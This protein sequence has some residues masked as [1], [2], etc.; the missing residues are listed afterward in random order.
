LVLHRVA[1][2]IDGPT[3]GIGNAHSEVAGVAHPRNGVQMAAVGQRAG[4]AE[5][6][7]SGAA[8]TDGDGAGV[9]QVDPEGHLCVAADGHYLAGGHARVA[10][11]AGQRARTSEREEPVARREIVVEGTAAEEH[12][13]SRHGTPLRERAAAHGEGAVVRHGA[14]VDE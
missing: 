12:S 8:I 1:G 3:G 4:A 11:G 14:V 2:E 5:Y 6:A 10:P 9:G 13:I 7:E